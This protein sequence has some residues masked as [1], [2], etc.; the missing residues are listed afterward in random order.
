MK[1]VKKPVDPPKIDSSLASYLQRPEVI[2]AAKKRLEA[3]EINRLER[4]AFAKG[5]IK[6]S[7][8]ELYAIAAGQAMRN[9]KSSYKG[10]EGI[11]KSVN[12]KK[13]LS[14]FGADV[15]VDSA[16]DYVDDKRKKK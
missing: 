2:A 14:A 15:A 3:E 6:P 13:A 11:V 7:Y 16:I 5:N 4:F 1:A 12:Y 8:P 9:A 10:L